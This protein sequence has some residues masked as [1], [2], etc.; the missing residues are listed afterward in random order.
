M[1]SFPPAKA[2]A[3]SGSGAVVDNT[4]TATAPESCSCAHCRMGVRQHCTVKNPPAPLTIEDLRLVLRGLCFLFVVSACS[5]GTCSP[6][7]KLDDGLESIGKDADLVL[8]L[9]AEALQDD[10]W[11]EIGS[12]SRIHFVN[13]GGSAFTCGTTTT[14]GCTEQLADDDYE[15]SLTVRP[16]ENVEDTAFAHEL[17]H[18]YAFAHGYA[19]G[20]CDHKAD[21]WRLNL[22]INSAM[23]LNRKHPEY[24]QGKDF[25]DVP[26]HSGYFSDPIYKSN[27]FKI[28]RYGNGD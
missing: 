9:G 17:L 15:I 25:P 16:G 19:D 23:D 26:P 11:K 10:E 12:K 22:L 13:K 14:G 1:Q 8:C 24:S 28:H 21:F 4:R 6:G 20:D 3:A 7:I 2:E 18:V 5:S 27:C